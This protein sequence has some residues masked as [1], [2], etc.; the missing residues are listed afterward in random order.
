MSY[1]ETIMRVRDA[2][3]DTELLIERHQGD[4]DDGTVL[5]IEVTVGYSSTPASQHRGYVR[6]GEE[7]FSR[8]ATWLYEHHDARSNDQWAREAAEAQQHE[9]RTAALRDAVRTLVRLANRGAPEVEEAVHVV[10]GWTDG[11]F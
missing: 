9:E 10:E 3:S 5:E 1:A 4:D 8:L 11:P 2:D 7:H 6:L